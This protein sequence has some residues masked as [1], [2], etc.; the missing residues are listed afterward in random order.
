MAQRKSTYLFPRNQKK[1]NKNRISACIYIYT[2]YKCYVLTANL[3]EKN[4]ATNS[5][6]DF[7][8]NFETSDPS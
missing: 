1:S 4:L 8:A 6:W 3:N 5:P 2:M 7:D